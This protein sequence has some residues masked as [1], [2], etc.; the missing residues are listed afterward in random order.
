VTETLPRKDIASG[1]F[2][3][4]SQFTFFRYPLDIPRGIKCDDSLSFSWP[5]IAL[6]QKTFEPEPRHKVRRLVLIVFSFFT[7]VFFNCFSANIISTLQHAKSIG[8]VDELADYTVRLKLNVERN[9]NKNAFFSFLE[10]ALIFPAR[11]IPN[12]ILI[13]SY[14][15]QYLR[16]IAGRYLANQLETKCWK[17]YEENA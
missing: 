5:L 15:N 14:C 16:F 2:S 7:L 1:I 10:N 8:N 12:G 11:G 4:F 3:H 9:C 13:H 6:S 17:N